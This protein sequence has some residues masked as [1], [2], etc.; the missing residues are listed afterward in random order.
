MVATCG[1]KIPFVNIKQEKFFFNK[2]FEIFTRKYINKNFNIDEEK[3]PRSI[4]RTCYSTILD[5]EKR[6]LPTVPNYEN[7][8]LPIVNCRRTKVKF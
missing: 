4:C 7:L 8:K 6:S 1:Q 5:N 2:C 3:F